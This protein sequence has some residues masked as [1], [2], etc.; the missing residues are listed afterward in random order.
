MPSFICIRVRSGESKMVKKKGKNILL[1]PLDFS[2]FSKAALIFAS[3]LAR[4]L[5]LQLLVLHV[6]HDPA[7]APGFYA[8]KGKKKKFLQSI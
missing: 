2:P 7:E 5:E 8:P 1:V 4:K 6:I 3:K